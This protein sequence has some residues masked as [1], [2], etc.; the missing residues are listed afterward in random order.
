[1]LD[2]SGTQRSNNNNNNPTATAIHWKQT[3]TVEDER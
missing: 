3:T 1:M 2:H